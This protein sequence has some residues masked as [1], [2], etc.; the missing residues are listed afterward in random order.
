AFNFVARQNDRQA[1]CF[2]YAASV[3]A[4]SLSIAVASMKY[5]DTNDQPSVTAKWGQPLFESSLYATSCLILLTMAGFFECHRGQ[6]F[7]AVHRGKGPVPFSVKFS[8]KGEKV[9][10]YLRLGLAMFGVM[11][12]AHVAVKFAED[13]REK[14]NDVLLYLKSILE[15]AFF[16]LQ[17]L[18]ILRYH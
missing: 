15:M 6:T 4:A 9:N 3:V 5:S 10:L 2:L 18:F 11:S 12:I 16:A 17:T 14:R 1:I 13:T 7:E 8:V